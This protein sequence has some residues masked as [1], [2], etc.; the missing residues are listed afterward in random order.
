MS[1]IKVDTLNE[2]S[3][4]GNIA[5]IPTGSGKLVL[6]GLT[7]PHA[8]GSA[9][10]IIK[11]NGSA[12]LSF[13]DAPGWTYG[14]EIENSSAT[15]IEFTGIPATATD[16]ELFFYLVSWTGTVTG[17]IVIGDS[18]GYETANYSGDSAA[19]EGTSINAATSDASAWYLRT[20]NGAGV[21]FN[22]VVRLKRMN[23][24]K[25]VYMQHTTANISADVTTQ[26]YASGTKA[27]SAVLDRIKMSG[28]T[29]DGN[30]TF[31][32]RYR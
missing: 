5:I 26:I 30:S 1:T 29:F 32:I 6:D 13:I 14:T 3:T 24:A 23:S 11:S 17:T 15:S 19:I 22:G 10:Q 7:W 31:Q 12:V 4:N 2:K 28:G 18:G 9:G 21:A 27:L 8:D 20:A 16:I 25:F